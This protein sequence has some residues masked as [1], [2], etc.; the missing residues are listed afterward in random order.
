M[1]ESIHPKW[2]PDAKV[3]V[4]GE[5]VMTVGSTKPEISV[6]VWS[7]THPFYTGTQRLMDTEGQVDRFMRRLQKREEIQTQ[8]ETVKQG[9]M[10]ENLSIE[11]MELGTR[12]NNALAAANLVTVG[13]VLELLKQGDD[14][15]LGLQ[16]VGQTALIKI[17][18]YMRDEELI[19]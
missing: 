6:E 8:T 12:A 17:K 14:A 11:E 16:G 7:G 3:I 10:P 15:V 1:K 13:D 4:E 9:R 5:V 2:Y 18:R 19:D